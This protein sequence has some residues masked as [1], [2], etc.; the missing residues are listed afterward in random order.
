MLNHLRIPKVIETQRN[1]YT[2]KTKKIW[3]F[4]SFPSSPFKKKFH[5]IIKINLI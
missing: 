4:L 3:D 1:H 2:E 5:S